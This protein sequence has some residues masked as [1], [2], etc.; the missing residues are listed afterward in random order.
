MFFFYTFIC[1]EISYDCLA[2]T[3]SDSGK[4]KFV[5]QLFLGIVV[6]LT[7]LTD[8]LLNFLRILCF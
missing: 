1:R 3:V 5:I 8:F 4:Y 2:S 7:S 6:Y